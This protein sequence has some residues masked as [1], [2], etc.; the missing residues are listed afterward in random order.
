MIHSIE[1]ALL[2][3]YTF[4][5]LVKKRKERKREKEGKSAQNNKEGNRD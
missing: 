2:Q 1:M 3:R 4:R 5:D